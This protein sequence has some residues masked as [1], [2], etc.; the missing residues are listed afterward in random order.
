[1]KR[2]LIAVAVALAVFGG[3][4]AFAASLGGVT[5][6]TVGDSATVVASCDTDGVA[7]SFSTPAWDGTL[8]HYGVTTLGVSGINTACNGNPI[9]V[10]LTDSTGASLGEAT[11]TV[12]AGAASLTFT[13]AVNTQSVEGIEVVI[14]S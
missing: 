8:Q 12:A 14:S 13:P 10:T 9:R 3:T 11:G 1:M 2:I 7:T 5:T 6:G 4:F